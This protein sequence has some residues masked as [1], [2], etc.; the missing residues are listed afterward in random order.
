MYGFMTIL[1]SLLLS[2][3]P[4]VLGAFDVRTKFQWLDSSCDGKDDVLNTAGQNMVDMA[5]AAE[6]ALVPEAGD[7]VK[8]TLKAFFNQEPQYGAVLKSMSIGSAR[9]LNHCR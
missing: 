9:K 1:L 7:V 8:R 6:D 2:S 5:S 3:V 4:L